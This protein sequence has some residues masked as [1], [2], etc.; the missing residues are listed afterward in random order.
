MSLLGPL[1]FRQRE[2]LALVADGHTDAE[3]AQLMGV[4]L[5]TVR[6]HVVDLKTKLGASSR[7]HAVALGYRTGQL[8]L[9][10]R[11]AS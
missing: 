3:I 10:T 9:D 8:T 1:S 4:G 11:E 5:A 2:T 6:R 7:A